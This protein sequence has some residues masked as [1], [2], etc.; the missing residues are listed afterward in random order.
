MKRIA[1]ALVLCL[2]ITGAA[3]AQNAAPSQ[4]ADDAILATKFRETRADAERGDV[5]AQYNL[6]MMYADGRGVAQDD[7]QALTWFRKA[8][9]QGN[10][11]AQD[12]LGF[13]YVNGR[14]RGAG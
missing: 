2:D 6:G 5:V 8:A 12:K 11:G 7:A 14:G 13:M 9:D 4:Q 1:L 3:L 10:A